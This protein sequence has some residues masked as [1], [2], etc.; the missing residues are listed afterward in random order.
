M[1]SV[2][3]LNERYHKLIKIIN[4]HNLLY[5]T[6]DSPIISDL[7][8]DELYNELKNIESENP[9]IIISDSP[10]QRVGSDLLSSFDKKKHDKPMLSLSNAAYQSDFEDFYIKLLSSIR[11]SAINFLQNLS[12]MDLL[13]G[14]HMKM[15]NILM[16]PQEEMVLLVKM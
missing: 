13:L 15:V 5:H 14:Y 3:R 9:K 11:L 7:E 6:Y 1:S 8:Y 4:Q 2:K 12:L 10:T 16:P